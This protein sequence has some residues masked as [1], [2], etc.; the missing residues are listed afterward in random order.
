MSQIEYAPDADNSL[1]A[2]A[3]RQTALARPEVCMPG[4]QMQGTGTLGGF[5]QTVR[6]RLRALRFMDSTPNAARGEQQWF[7]P[8]NHPKDE[9]LFLHPKYLKSP[10][11]AHGMR[12][13]GD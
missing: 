11:A 3:V 4:P 10:G 7:A 8:M 6:L 12:H 13:C 9:D 1:Q 2:P 5:R